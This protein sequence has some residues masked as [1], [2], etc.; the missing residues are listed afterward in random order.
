M[1]FKLKLHLLF[2][3]HISFPWQ[4]L[5]FLFA[6]SH[7]NLTRSACFRVCVCVQLYFAKKFL[8]M[9]MVVDVLPTPMDAATTFRENYSVYGLVLLNFV[10]LLPSGVERSLREI[11]PGDLERGR[12]SLVVYNTG[13]ASD[14]DFETLERAG[15]A[16]VLEEPYSLEVLKVPLSIWYIICIGI[17]NCYLY[18]VSIWQ[19]V[20]I[21]CKFLL[22]VPSTSNS[23]KVLPCLI[24]F[25]CVQ[26]ML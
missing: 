8:Q 9:D 5:I 22:F 19:F 17:F 13:N 6:A 14:A 1:Q 11:I 10:D 16:D 20:C 24:L 7:N 18:K 26:T 4:A 21:L 23:F 12:Y 2:Y 25:S 15:V 3:A